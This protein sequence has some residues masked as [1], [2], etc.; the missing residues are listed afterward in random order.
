MPG[1]GRTHGSFAITA[2]VTL[3]ALV[4]TAPAAA[5][6]VS[7]AS[8][9]FQIIGD[10][11]DDAITLS[12]TPTAITVVDTGTGGVTP[13]SNCAAVNGQTVTCTTPPGGVPFQ[14]FFA[15]LGS[16]V[17]SFVNVDLEISGSVGSFGFDTGTKTINGGPGTQGISGGLDSDMLDGGPGEDQLFGGG[18]TVADP[19][20]GNDTLI[21][22]PGEDTTQFFREVPTPLTVTLDGLPNDG[23]AGEADNV[24][25]ENV[26]GDQGNDTLIGDASAN[27]LSGGEGADQVS[28]LGGNDRLFGDFSG[29]GSPNRGLAVTPPLNDVLDGG[30]GRDDVDCGGDFDLVLHDPFDQISPNCER[31]GAILDAD[32]AALG[33]KKRNKAKIG[34]ECPAAEDAACIG[35]LSLTANDKAIGAGS[36]NVAP[37]TSKRGKAKLSKKGVKAVKNANG[38][39]LASVTVSTTEP[40]GVAESSG[41]ILIY[42]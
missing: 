25:T 23:Q 22:G 4:A 5:S 15:I 24:Q 27:Q 32:S 11:D 14:I 9:A 19:T 1:R 18:G 28:G 6:M 3:F 2:L 17:D 33:G 29:N 40:G 20:G 39:L 34:V 8:G 30:P 26:L 38:T 37:G 31:T 10:N 13:G 35:T 7:A 36:F 21:G 41:R 16:G 12:G 42:E